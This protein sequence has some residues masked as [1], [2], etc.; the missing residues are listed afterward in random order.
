RSC[1]SCSF[2]WCSRSCSWCSWCSAWWSI[3]PPQ[4]VI[5]R[6]APRRGARPEWL[7]LAA[8]VAEHLVDLFLD[9]LQVE[10]GRVLHRRVL[11]GRLG[12]VRHP[13]LDEDEP[14]ELPGEEVVPVAERPGQR[15]LAAD[16]RE[17]LERVLTDVHDPGHV[18]D[19]LRPGPALRLREEL[20]LEVV[21]AQRTQLRSGEVEE[22]V[23]GARPLAG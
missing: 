8:L 21:D 18:G 9:R 16:H 23:P 15:R 22:L 11:E 19:H 2:L 14:P 4:G 17:P 7:S 12:Q 3:G 13:L 5:E 1:A 6:R 20:E 10:G